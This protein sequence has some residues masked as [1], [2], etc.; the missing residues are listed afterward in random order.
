MSPLFQRAERRKAKLR[1]AIEG[2]SGSGKTLSALLIAKGLTHGDL[3]KVAVLDTERGSAS[4][5]AHVGPYSVLNFEPPYSPERYMKAIAA[6]EAEGFEVIVID[7]LTHAWSG[8]GGLLDFVDK[9][10]KAKTSGNSFAAWKEGSP[11]QAR[12]MDAMLKSPCHVISTMRSKTEWVLEENDKGKKVPRKIGLA[13]DQRK[14]IDYEYTLVLSLSRDHIASASKDRTG[15]FDDRLEVPSEAMGA[16]LLAWLEEG[17]ESG[18][19]P[20]A[21]PRAPE[22]T[23]AAPTPAQAQSQEQA[24][25]IPRCGPQE[26]EHIT[27]TDQRMIEMLVVAKGYKVE[28]VE[29]SL[30]R[31]GLCTNGLCSLPAEKLT[32]VIEVISGLK[33]KE[34]PQPPTEPPSQTPAPAPEQSSATAQTPA[35]QTQEAPLAGA[36]AAEQ[37]LP[38]W[39]KQQQE[40]AAAEGV[41]G[42]GSEDGEAA[43]DKQIEEMA[44]G[45]KITPAL[46]TRLGAL[47]SQLTAAGIPE[48][49][50]RA[51]IFTLTSGRTTS[52]KELT[53]VEAKVLS[54]HL[55]ALLEDT[56]AAK[57][58]A[59]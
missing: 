42:V 29:A 56:R 57:V 1:L 28:D 52:R 21:S 19:A 39:M 32:H 30:R 58:G 54:V 34:P 53:D 4:L 11:L 5:Y 46:L 49:Q 24:A 18:S 9:V 14:D 8:E 51:E 27:E 55:S 2:P 37:P 50:W 26:P 23:P 33:T 20:Q 10:A 35:P 13:P 22:A 43:I 16:E 3:S 31:A 41:P 48:D 17:L 45:P 6:A 7:S 40:E 15:I 25:D 38:D 44:S 36:P 12:L 59:A 47:G